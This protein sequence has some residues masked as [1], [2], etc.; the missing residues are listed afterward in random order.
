MNT[1][2]MMKEA[3]D[4]LDDDLPLILVELHPDDESYLKR[5]FENNVRVSMPHTVKCHRLLGSGVQV[6]PKN[7]KEYVPVVYI[8]RIL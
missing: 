5:S 8:T 1:V 6:N 7:T 4:G 3:L 2:A